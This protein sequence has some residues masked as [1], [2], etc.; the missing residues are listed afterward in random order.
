MKLV[1]QRLFPIDLDHLDRR[2]FRQENLRLDHQS[3]F[4]VHWWLGQQETERPRLQVH[5]GAVSGHLAFVCVQGHRGESESAGAGSEI[6]MTGE[7]R[8]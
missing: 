2:A 7:G 8:L 6:D 1:D 5:V 4:L 3:I